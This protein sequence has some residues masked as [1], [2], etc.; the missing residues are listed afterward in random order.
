VHTNDPVIRP[1]GI[2][3]ETV[4]LEYSHEMMRVKRDS[5]FR[6]AETAKFVSVLAFLLILVQFYGHPVRL[7]RMYVPTNV[8]RVCTEQY[9]HAYRLAEAHGVDQWK[10]GTA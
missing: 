2:D 8:S 5:S 1:E 9:M 3:N 4:I 10:D 7:L 6:V